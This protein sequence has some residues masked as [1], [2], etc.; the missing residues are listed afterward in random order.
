MTFRSAAAA[1][2][3][4]VLIALPDMASAQQQRPPQAGG[5]HRIEDFTGQ[6]AARP[7]GQPGVEI[8]SQRAI[9]IAREL[10]RHSGEGRCGTEGRGR[11][12]GR[13]SHINFRGVCDNG[14]P[15]PYSRCAVTV[16]TPDRLSTRCQN[17][18][19]MVLYRV[20]R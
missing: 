16:E 14:R 13:T 2:A 1:F 3:A 18:H 20:S 9:L 7:G 12:T 19:R 4:T 5:G 17:G 8:R 11:W 10:F 15:M 6:W